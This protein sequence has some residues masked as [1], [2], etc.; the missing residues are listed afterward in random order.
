[1][2]ADIGMVQMPCPELCC[3]GLDRG[4]AEGAGSPVVVENTR[5][6]GALKQGEAS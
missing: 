4:N 2:N 3:L 5:I 6:L 1:M